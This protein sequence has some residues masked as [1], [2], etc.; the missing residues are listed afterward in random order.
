MIDFLIAAAREAM[1]S[2]NFWMF[3]AI[4]FVAQIFDGTLGMGFGVLSSTTLTAMGYP[5]AAVSGAVNGAKIFTGLASGAAHIYFGNVDWRIFLR[6]VL[7]GLAGAVPG[8][9]LVGHAHTNWLG[10]ALSLY[11]IG[12]GIFL[13]WKV[14]HADARTPSAGQHV[15]I[16]IAGGFLEAISG[17]W[18]PLVT[19]TMVATGTAPRK[20]VGTVNLAEFVIAFVVLLMLAKHINE[21]GL[22]GSILALVAGAVLAAPFA[23]RLTVALPRKQL[24]YGVGALVISTS[25]IRLVRDI[26]KI[27]G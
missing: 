20:I 1:A 6:L 17:V 13:I 21:T 27:I 10:V 8:A 16:G 9:F 15:R 5:R 12:V 24:I 22:G 7:G 2:P 18:G 23:A 19:S 26:D 4:G 25:L 14:A 3:F 11:L